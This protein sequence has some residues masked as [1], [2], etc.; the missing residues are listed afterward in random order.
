VDADRLLGLRSEDQKKELLNFWLQSKA[1]RDRNW[2]SFFKLYW[3]KMDSW[4]IGSICLKVLRMLSIDPRFEQ[5]E[6]WKKHKP[7]LQEVLRSLLTVNPYKRFDCLEALSLLDPTNAI[8]S[9]GSGNEWITTR[10][11]QRAATS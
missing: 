5:N 7:V 3:T 8:I 4:A 2:V 11:K 6:E 10:A 9:E 1:I